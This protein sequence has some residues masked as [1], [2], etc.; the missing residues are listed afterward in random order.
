MS[1]KGARS[2]KRQAALLILMLRCCVELCGRVHRAG[3]LEG[4]ADCDG[5]GRGGGGE[6]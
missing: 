3:K 1:R 2:P 6:T 5:G 4:H